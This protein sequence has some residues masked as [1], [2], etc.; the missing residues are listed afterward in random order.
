MKYPYGIL[1]VGQRLMESGNMSPGL[2]FRDKMPYETTFFPTIQTRDEELVYL[3]K[4]FPGR[5]FVSFTLNHMAFTEPGEMKTL[6]YTS[7]G[8][9]K[10]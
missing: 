3:A 7:E 6:A 5:T 1:E 4:Q 8:L 10:T 9:L 2:S